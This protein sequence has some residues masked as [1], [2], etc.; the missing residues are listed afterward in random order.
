MEDAVRGATARER[1]M[2][3]IT[4]AFAILAMLVAAVGLY[5]VFA[6]TVAQRTSEIG[7]RLALGATRGRVRWMVLRQVGATALI[8]GTL[9]IVS[10]LVLGRAAQSLLFGLEFHDTG[11]LLSSFVI[12]AL[13][14]LAA[15]FVP[16]NRACRV[17]PIRALKYE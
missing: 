15:G 10:A 3:V 5:G 1:L 14:A 8:G 6:Y 13:V 16:A 9:G 7:L 2:S 12:L 11:V 4:G 17:D